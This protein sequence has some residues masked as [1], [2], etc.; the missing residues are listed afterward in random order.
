M[1]FV[2]SA[3]STVSV[4]VYPIVYTGSLC[5]IGNV[6]RGLSGMSAR[7]V[8]SAISPCVCPRGLLCLL[9]PTGYAIQT[10]YCVLDERMCQYFL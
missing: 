8:I 5:Y 10:M 1:I 2:V 4:W 3:I 6:C 7:S 9:S